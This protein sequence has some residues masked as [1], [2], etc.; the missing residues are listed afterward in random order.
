MSGAELAVALVFG[1]V[2][3]AVAVVVLVIPAWRR[4]ED[5][6]ARWQQRRGEDDHTDPHS[7]GPSRSH[8]GG[9]GRPGR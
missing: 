6:H 7:P 1:L 4:S 8:W 5:Q 9:W 2:V 3:V